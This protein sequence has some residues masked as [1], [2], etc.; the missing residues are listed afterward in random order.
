[1]VSFIQELGVD[2]ISSLARNPPAASVPNIVYLTRPE[3]AYI[4]MIAQHVK[5]Y[6]AE[7]AKHPGMVPRRVHSLDQAFFSRHPSLSVMPKLSKAFKAYNE[8]YVHMMPRRRLF[9]EK[10]FED[11]GVIDGM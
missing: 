9:C 2:D 11:E 1:M 5:Y 4:K 3:V 8:I 6:R 10:I 7:E